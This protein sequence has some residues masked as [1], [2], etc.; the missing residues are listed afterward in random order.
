MISS[1]NTHQLTLRAL[2]LVGWVICFCLASNM[3]FIQSCKVNDE[4]SD[5]TISSALQVNKVDDGSGFI[6]EASQSKDDQSIHKCELSEHLINFDHHQ[7][8][9]QAIF[10]Y[11]ILIVVVSWLLSTVPYFP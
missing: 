10:T 7:I 8:N 2:L 5:S 9:D 6:D 4:N 1:R 3:S 11:F